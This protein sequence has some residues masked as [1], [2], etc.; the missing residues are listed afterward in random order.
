MGINQW[1]DADYG[2]APR[3]SAGKVTTDP[4]ANA[5][6]WVFFAVTYYAIAKEVSFYFGNNTRNAVI[7]T[8]VTYDRGAVGSNISRLAIGHFNVAT[9]ANALDRM[10]RG[11]MDE[12]NI[13]GG[14]LTAEQIV[15][16]QNDVYNGISIPTIA[17]AVLYPNPVKDKLFLSGY[18]DKIIVTD[19]HGKEVLIS[20]G[21]TVDF[22]SLANGVYIVK[23]FVGQ[24]ISISKIIK[25]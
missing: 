9:R 13:F 3:S 19:I 21:S 24:G 4:D 23:C 18:A 12:I 22:A 16:V 1:S 17:N 20:K 11:L 14:A 25:Q 5:G 7:D 8:T 10:F 2:I 15:S 6:N